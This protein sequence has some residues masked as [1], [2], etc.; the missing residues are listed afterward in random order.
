MKNVLF[1]FPY[2]QS[3]F[4]SFIMF[5]ALTILP[6]S[7]KAQMAADSIGK[8]SV[9]SVVFKQ[10]EPF[11]FRDSD[12]LKGYSIDLLNLLSKE[13]GFTYSV[14]EVSTMSK[15]IEEVS[16]KKYNIGLGATSITEE[17][18]KI[19]DFSYPFFE[20][21]LQVLVRKSGDNGPWST[22]KKVFNS[23]FIAIIGILCLFILFIS[24]LI[25]LFERK[26]NSESFPV[27]YLTGVGES[28][29]WSI[30]T[31]I[32]GG[33]EN[34]SPIGFSGRL[35][36]FIWMLGAILLT[37]FITASLTA[38]MTINTLSNDIKG[39]SDLRGKKIGTVSGGYS[40]GFLKKSG[41]NVIGQKTIDDAILLLENGKVSGIVFDS[42][43][44]NYFVK[45]HPGSDLQVIGP[46]FENQNYGFVLPLGSNLRKDIN[47]ALLKLQFSGAINDL[48]KKWFDTE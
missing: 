30:S 5:L 12:R 38:S 43:V 21:G 33:C 46:I 1:R 45:T 26:R 3:N 14:S 7:F 29:W 23:E 32:S 6:A 19:V 25:W 40:D 41:Y 34:K 47:K 11:A 20:S 35:V 10:T 27:K 31:L 13:C 15:L 24:H 2:K 18:E 39:I 37:T 16:Q 22:I 36:A 9:L 48:K 28:I 8:S 4:F 44:L 17:R 42:P